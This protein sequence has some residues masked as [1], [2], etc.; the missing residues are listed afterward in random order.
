M[1]Q[2]VKLLIVNYHYIRY[3]IPDRG[4]HPIHP[5][6]FRK[7]LR[8]IQNDNYEFISLKLLNDSIKNKNIKN[9]PERA[10]LITFDDGLKESYEIGLK[11][12]DDMEIPA[13]F[14]ISTDAVIH[15]KVNNV[16]KL[17]YIRSII[18]ANELL[19]DLEKNFHVNVSKIRENSQLIKKTFP[20]D[21]FED[22]TLKYILNFYISDNERQ[23]MTEYFFNLIYSGSEAEFAN[24]FYMNNEHI[25]DLNN[26]NYLG[27]HTKSH[28]PLEHLNEE[29]IKYEISES[30]RD[31]KSIVKNN[32]FS[33]S[34]PYGLRVSFN[35]SIYAICKELGLIS[36]FTMYRGINT[37]EDILGNS[38]FLKRLDKNDV[39]GGKSEVQYRGLMID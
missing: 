24:N 35:Q 26:R 29:Q 16:H 36:G 34:Y 14:F 4:I 23:K 28:L 13:A 19:N 2:D 10:C 11:I 3:K 20:Y 15:N 12:L 39:Y 30:L 22:A 27:T 9:L 17:H 18:K 33:I 1:K 5:D 21:G 31:I 38:F 6:D 32:I 25:N 8:L 7:Q 37:A